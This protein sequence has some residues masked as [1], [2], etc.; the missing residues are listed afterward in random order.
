MLLQ[1]AMQL[2]PV[3]INQFTA[4]VGTYTVTVGDFAGEIEL[5]EH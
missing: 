2:A 5:L 4:E 3:F 1:H